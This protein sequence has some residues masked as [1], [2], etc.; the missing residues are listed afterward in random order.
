M[1]MPGNIPTRM[2]PVQDHFDDDNRRIEDAI[3]VEDQRERH[4][5]GRKPIAKSAI[6]SG[7]E[8]SDAGKNDHSG[9]KGG[10]L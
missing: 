1:A 4:G 3:G 6:Y 5:E 2:G 8:Q 10:H 9:V 7:R